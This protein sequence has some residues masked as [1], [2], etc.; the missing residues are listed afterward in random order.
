MFILDI[1]E[2]FSDALNMCDDPSRAVCTNT[3]GSFECS[4]R[5]GFTG[6]GENC[7]GQF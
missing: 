4:C 6:N 7:T 1:D 3:I 2:C 5:D